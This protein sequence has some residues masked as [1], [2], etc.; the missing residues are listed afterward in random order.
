MSFK[1][2]VNVCHRLNVNV[3]HWKHNILPKSYA[4]NKMYLRVP[5]FLLEPLSQ[6]PKAVFTMALLLT[7]FGGS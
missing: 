2:N 3:C 6:S 1:L 7:V 4:G 5:A